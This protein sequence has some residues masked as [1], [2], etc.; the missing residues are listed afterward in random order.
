MKVC[1]E[2]GTIVRQL[3]VKI[4]RGLTGLATCSRPIFFEEED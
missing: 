2:D 3:I 1:F 4:G